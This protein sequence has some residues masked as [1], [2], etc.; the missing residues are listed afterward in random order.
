[1][2][3][4]KDNFFVP[5][6]ALSSLSNGL[7]AV[8]AVRAG[9]DAPVFA[10]WLILNNVV[11]QVVRQSVL[12]S[13][14]L[15]NSRHD[16]T[17]GAQLD[18][19]R[20]T[21]LVAGSVL[22]VGAA[23]GFLV[24]PLYALFA[25]ITFTILVQDGLRYHSFAVDRAKSAFVSDLLWSVSALVGATLTILS[26]SVVLGFACWSTGPAAGAIV[27]V[28]RFRRDRE[29]P[30]TVIRITGR[31]SA[32][33]EVLIHQAQTP[34]LLGIIALAGVPEDTTLL[35]VSRTVLG[36]AVIVVVGTQSGLLVRWSSHAGSAVPITRTA[37]TLTI[38]VGAYVAAAAVAFVF[39]G[40]EIFS[41]P[42]SSVAVVMLPLGVAYAMDAA[43]GIARISLRA[44]GQSRSTAQLR[45][46]AAALQIGSMVGG[47]S[48]GG[49]VGALAG[50]AVGSAVSAATYVAFASRSSQATSMNT[51]A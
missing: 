50:L 36:P 16:A 21:N 40:E 18:V 17:V 11:V 43:I 46:V 48:L 10:A 47:A 8:I 51:A 22:A 30:H 12:E 6:Q 15:S 35:L 29:W 49:T 37:V 34:V 1:M 7:F 28:L 31:R 4:V 14:L 26:G 32:L 9:Q 20:R 45:L 42:F 3:S 23:G 38:L 24:D 27:S 19:D 44:A 5:D 41:V 33:F 2:K 39:I 25:V 13:T